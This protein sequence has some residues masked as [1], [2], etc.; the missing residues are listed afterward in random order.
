MLRAAV[1]FLLP[2]ASVRVVR[3]L[4]L[5]KKGGGGGSGSCCPALWLHP[6]LR[7]AHRVPQ[8]GMCLLCSLQAH[9]M[10]HSVSEAA[11]KYF[12]LPRNVFLLVLIFRDSQGEKNLFNEKLKLEQSVVSHFAGEG[13]RNFHLQTL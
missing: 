3:I 2:L 13:G 10:P 6:A 12:L 11:S 4:Q 9:T 8:H 7:D 5:I 1:A